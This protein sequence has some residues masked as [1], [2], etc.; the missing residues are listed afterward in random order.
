MKILDDIYE[1]AHKQDLEFLLIGGHAINAVGERRQTGD[2]DLVV[3][4]ADKD[5]WKQLLLNLDYEIFNESNAFL[6]S[7]SPDIHQWPVD[8]MLVD[9]QTFN[10][11]KEEA[12]TVN[13]GG[14]YDVLIPS[15]EHLVAMKLHALKQ[16]SPKGRLKD[17]VDI[18]A[19]VREGG[20]ETR[21]DRFRQL[22]EKYATMD[23]YE[24][25]I[26]TI[27]RKQEQ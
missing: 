14:Q 22:C 9:D 11:L 5:N 17:L 23:I 6:Q 8:I 27:D 18:A 4:E 12:K 20:I 21:G 13:L 19:L 10:G 25:I 26:R 16:G 24:E 7:Q 3:R 1:L 15:I 2:V